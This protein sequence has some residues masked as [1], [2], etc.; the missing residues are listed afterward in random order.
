MKKNLW[1]HQMSPHI[2]NPWAKE[3]SIPPGLSVHYQPCFRFLLPIIRPSPFL[4]PDIYSSLYR[5]WRVPDVLAAHAARVTHSPFLFLSPILAASLSQ[6]VCVVFLLWQLLIAVTINLL[7]SLQSKGAIY[8]MTV[9]VREDKQLAQVTSGKVGNKLKTW[10]FV[11]LEGN[12]N[13]NKM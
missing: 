12:C 10:A 4:S 1:S 13:N 7:H 9:H 5:S 8:R 2:Q 6:A 11:W 3:S